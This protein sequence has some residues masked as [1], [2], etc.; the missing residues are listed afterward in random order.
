MPRDAQAAFDNGR[1]FGEVRNVDVI[2]CELATLSPLEYEQQ[3]EEMAIQLNIRKSVLDD[4]V[5][6]ELVRS[7]EVIR[8]QGSLVA[9]KFIQAEDA[10]DTILA[11][12]LITK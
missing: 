3:R 8:V 6:T 7:L 11:D 12:Y 5:R 1:A 9:G 10:F 4:E 2:L